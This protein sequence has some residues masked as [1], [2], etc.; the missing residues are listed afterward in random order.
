MGQS[1]DGLSFN[2]CSTLFPCISF[3]EEQFWVKYLEMSGRP[4]PQSVGHAELLNMILTGSPSPLRGI[5]PWAPGRLLLSWHLGHSGCYLHLPIPHCY[6][7]LF[8][9]LTLFKSPLS[10]PIPNF[11]LPLFSSSQVPPTYFHCLFYFTF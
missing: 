5:S 4:I 9:F 11:P 6:K 10:P 7:L 2:L 1:L 8:N 3:R